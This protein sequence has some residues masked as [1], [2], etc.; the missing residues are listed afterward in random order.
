MI[1]RLERPLFYD[2]IVAANRNHL[3]KRQVVL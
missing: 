3:A 1:I 2:E